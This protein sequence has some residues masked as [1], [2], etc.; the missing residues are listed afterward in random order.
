MPL[1]S[2]LSRDANWRQFSHHLVDRNVLAS[3]ELLVAHGRKCTRLLTQGQLRQ[4]SCT[5][6]PGGAPKAQFTENKGYR[7]YSQK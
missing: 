1:P 3:P 7:W 2:V 5:D 6:E 4:G